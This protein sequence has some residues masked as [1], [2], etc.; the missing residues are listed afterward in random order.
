MRMVYLGYEAF[1]TAV[2]LQVTYKR[3]EIWIFLLILIR[4][5]SVKKIK[6]ENSGDFFAKIQA[7]KV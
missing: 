4:C 5:K 2:R 3:P 7:A 1:V 6:M